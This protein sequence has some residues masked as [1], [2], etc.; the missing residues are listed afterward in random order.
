MMDLIG[1]A[2]S[3]N[4]IGTHTEAQA[5]ELAMLKFI[6]RCDIDY[7][8][9]RKIYVPKDMVRFQFDSARKRMSTL[10]ELPD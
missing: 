8:N 4:T 10:I 7:E 9:M 1:Q 2:V 3:C 5:T 6:V